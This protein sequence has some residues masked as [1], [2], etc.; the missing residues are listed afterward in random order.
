[1]KNNEH[2]PIPEDFDDDENKAESGQKESVSV[3]HIHKI[4][5]SD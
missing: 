2:F 3:Y 1:M 4:L 5:S